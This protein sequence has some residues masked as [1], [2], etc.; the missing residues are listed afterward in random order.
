MCH[1]LVFTVWDLGF[2]SC[3]EEVSFS[4]AA[5]ALA[6]AEKRGVQEEAIY[7]ITNGETSLSG[8]LEWHTVEQGTSSHLLFAVQRLEQY[9]DRAWGNV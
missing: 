8:K 3:R 9:S 1:E 6:L 4:L 2:S 5:L 7:T